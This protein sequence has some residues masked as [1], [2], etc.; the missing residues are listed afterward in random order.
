[1]SYQPEERYWTDY[2]RIALPV[3]GLLLMLGLFWYWASAVIGDDDSNDPGSKPT[4]VVALITQ[5]VPTAT[6]TPEV[7]IT[8]DNVTPEPTK[9]PATNGSGD[10]A[11]E[12]P[13]NEP[14]GGDENT[15]E[16]PGKGF[17]EGD[18]VVTNTGDVNLRSEKSTG[19]DVVEVLA[20]GTELEVTE[21]ATE[22]D[23]DGYY[24]VGVSTSD[25]DLSGYVA[26]KFLDAST[27]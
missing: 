26:D 12:E 1:V 6:N 22:K 2:L 17:K 9:K 18:T 4:S 7:Q 14:S 25:G 19:S 27:Q 11:T 23:A 16:I 20:E 10:E 15:P 21:P 24:W 3:V 8:P 13:T 5:P